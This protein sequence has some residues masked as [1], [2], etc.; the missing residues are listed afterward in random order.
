MST[1]KMKRTL[2]AVSI[3]LAGAAHA[4]PVLLAENSAV[5]DAWAQAGGQPA[6]VV[7]G[8]EG[9]TRLEWQ[10]NVALD[11]YRTEASGGN[12][13]T[14][15]STGDYRSL[16]LNSN[17]QRQR[18]AGDISTGLLG[19]A[20]VNDR[21][22]NRSDVHI[23][24]LQLTHAQGNS[25]FALG[26]V[27]AAYSPLGVNL[28]LRGVQLD[29]KVG[30]ATIS[31]VLG[32]VAESWETLAQEVDAT[33]AQRNVAAARLEMPAGLDG[34]RASAS[35]AT[36]GDD[37]GNLD[38]QMAAAPELSGDVGTI[39]LAFSRQRYQLALEAGFSRWEQE[40]G[41]SGDDK[42]VTVDAGWQ[43]EKAGV[44]AG[45]HDIGS[46]YAGLSGQAMGGVSETY[47]A[48]T[49][50]AR[51]WL[52]LNSDLRYSENAARVTTTPAPAVQPAT[53]SDR[54]MLGAGIRFPQW[55]A[56]SLQLSA[57]SAQGENSD[58]SDNVN[59]NGSV[60]LAL[61]RDDWYGNVGSQLGTV[62][63][64]APGASAVNG[65]LTTLS[66]G[67]GRRWAN[68]AGLAVD[69][70]FNAN[71]QQQDL[72]SG[73]ST[74]SR[75]GN[76]NL[77]ASHER[78]GRAAVVAMLGTVTNPVTGATLDQ[79]SWQVDYSYPLRKHGQVG[80]FWRDVSDNAGDGV[81]ESSTTSWGLKY[82]GTF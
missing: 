32:V 24:S 60:M 22:V 11:V 72:D 39:G 62:K 19:L 3:S 64:D 79:S 36:H 68:L 43:G 29:Q 41:A 67:L 47:L 75:S 10:N 55:P 6:E 12:T 54:A 26:D 15:Q 63:N 25:R 77:S 4:G 73:A 70:G 7:T 16:S 18:A 30:Q 45:W 61:T 59:H 9:G 65:D 52:A 1:N 17:F 2:L 23:G 13:L 38:G 5:M 51:E 76:L 35:I 21:A 74:E 80:L 8:E 78:A 82:A 48:G 33:A 42:A 28:G 50:Q 20:V 53:R 31:G 56:L 27:A 46:D 58:G 71:D 69:I 81:L 14:P 40:G 34:L 44:R 37:A 49:W 57:Q 66:L